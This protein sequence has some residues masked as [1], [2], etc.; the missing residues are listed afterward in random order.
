MLLEL[1]W[2]CT[3][4]WCGDVQQAGVGMY[5]KLVW[6]CTTSWCGD[7]QQT[8]Q[9]RERHVRIHEITM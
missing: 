8:G 9:L 4:N 7:V 5:N 1:V 3:T 6:G 2:G